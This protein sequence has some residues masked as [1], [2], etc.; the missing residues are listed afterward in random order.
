MCV[1]VGVGFFNART[2]SKLVDDISVHTI[3][4]IVGECKRVFHE[5]IA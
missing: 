5:L 2:N 4:S 1:C 3:F